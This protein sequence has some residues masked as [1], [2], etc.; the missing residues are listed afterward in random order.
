MS[1]LFISWLV[2]LIAVG[3]IAG[4]ALS[5]MRGRSF[6]R[7]H[8][9]TDLSGFL[10]GELHAFFELLRSYATHAWRPLANWTI[11]KSAHYV[12]RGHDMFMERVYGRVEIE[13]GKAASFFL[14]RIAEH[15]EESKKN[16]GA[17]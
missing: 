1:F 17:Y 9:P 3:G 14:K 7:E 8:E 2:S 11:D 13:R 12:T 6:S 16:G 5:G 15:K 10:S 4:M